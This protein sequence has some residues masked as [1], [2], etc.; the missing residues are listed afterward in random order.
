[1][2][3]LI[4]VFAFGVASAMTPLT[5][6]AQAQKS[7]PDTQD[8]LNHGIIIG[9]I[10][11]IIL[12]ACVL[13]MSLMVRFFNQ[14]PDV[15]TLA[16]PY[17]K[18]ISFS[19]FPMIMF[20]ILKKFMEGFS[21]VRPAM[22]IILLGNLVH[23]FFNWILIYGKWGF[24]A[25]GLNGAGIGTTLGRF[26]M[27][28]MMI[29]FMWKSPAFRNYISHVQIFK[30]KSTVVREILRLGIPS[31]I[32]FFSEVSAFIFAIIVIGW[33]GT[34]ELAAHE[35][36]MN[37]ASIT[38]M[39]MIGISSAATIRVSSAFGKNDWKSV[40]RAGITAI[41]MGAMI[42]GLFGVIFILFRHMLPWI[43]VDDIAVVGITSKLLIIAA[44]FQIFDGI[45]AV[46]QGVLR[47]VM[48]VRFPMITAIM[49][50]WVIGLPVGYFLGFYCHYGVYGVWM[51]LAAG[52]ILMAISLTIWFYK[53]LSKQSI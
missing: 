47:G 41:S 7:S 52:I 38:F 16:I 12:T 4:A 23:I 37:M 51:G 10:T 20:E 44:I 24:P 21:V 49:A 31:G 30:L 32:Q 3:F 15:V 2:F 27:V 40:K 13:A 9:I 33:I 26:T 28:I 50:Y 39:S 5:S 48:S 29:G 17:M 45:Q 22:I 36:A 43:Y 11:S 42:M 8:I 46:A 1:L 35:I 34:P 14:P 18:I 25:L 53:I 6:I 19:I